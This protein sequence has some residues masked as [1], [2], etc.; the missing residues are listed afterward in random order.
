MYDCSMWHVLEHKSIDRKI[1]KPPRDVQEKYEKWI[2]IVQQSGP[3]GLR[4][5]R[6]FND[7]ALRGEWKGSRSSRLSKQYRVICQ[8]MKQEVVVS[9]ID[10]TAH[11]YRKR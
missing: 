7:E 2:D 3:V 9:V 10:I 6:G 4:T 1:K 5:I 8:I 11:D